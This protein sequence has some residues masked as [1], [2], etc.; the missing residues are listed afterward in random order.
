MLGKGISTQSPSAN[1]EFPVPFLNH[2]DDEDELQ[3]DAVSRRK[4]LGSGPIAATIAWM[5]VS[6]TSFP[7]TAAAVTLTGPLDGNL[8]ELP[9]DAVR[10]YLQYRIP[11]Q[12][13]ADYYIF[14]LQDMV[15]DVE[16]WGDVGQLFRVNNN[17]GQ[18]QPSKVERDYNSPMKILLLSFPPDVAE[19]MRTVQFRFEK[20]MNTISKATSGYKKD[21]PI[22]IDTKSIVEAKQGWEEGR[23]ALNDF[24]ALVNTEVGM[25]E[26][27][28]IPS[29]G[30]N[31]FN[32]Y[33]RSARRFKD[34]L[35]KTKLCQNRYVFLL[36]D[37]DV[38]LSLC[39]IEDELDAH[40][41]FVP[42]ALSVVVVQRCH[43]LGVS[44]T[45]R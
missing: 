23:V 28:P 36:I 44:H 9:R 43:K 41:F 19:E 21:L 26:L 6:T 45:T 42:V 8:P 24:F 40:H 33:G 2:D 17:K 12:I 18:G 10:S 35:K 37:E 27:K 32:E 7:S 30:P 25:S 34:L 13:A 22:E 20:A 14:S 5:T 39:R 16:Q 38:I 3:R 29:P 1:I 31:Q 11:L 15:F 4:F